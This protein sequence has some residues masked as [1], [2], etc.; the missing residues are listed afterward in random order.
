VRHDRSDKFVLPFAEERERGSTF[1]PTAIL[2]TALAVAAFV[3]LQTAISSVLAICSVVVLVGSLG[4]TRWKRVLSL[5]AKFEVIILFWVLLEPV[6]YGSTIVATF[7][8]PWG[9]LHVYSEGIYLGILLGTRMFTIL[10]TFMG[11]LSHISL[12]D[13]VGSLRTLRVPQSILGSML[14]MFRYV[15][16]FMEERSRMQD[17]QKLRGYERGRRIERITHLGNLVGTSINRSF[18]RSVRVY[19]SMSLRGFGRGMIVRGAGFRKRDVLLP[20]AFLLLL[21]SIPFL[22]YAIAEVLIL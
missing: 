4:K 21:L 17:A 1:S 7:E 22:S 19:E 15:P 11:A 5:A 10:L 13:F 16:L 9:P 20:M 18:D 8:F 12:T 14:I 6:L 2:L 3:S